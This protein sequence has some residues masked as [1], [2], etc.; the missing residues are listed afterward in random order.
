MVIFAH[1]SGRSRLSSRNR[2]VASVLLQAGSGTLLL[3]LL[4]TEEKQVDLGTQHLRFDVDL[5]A[6]RLVEATEWMTTDSKTGNLPV[7]YWEPAQALQ[8]H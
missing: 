3:D 7:G 2:F 5:L 6:S 4:N 1:G 8:P